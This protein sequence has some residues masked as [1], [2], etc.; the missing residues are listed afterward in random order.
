MSLFN[1][2]CEP[3][4]LAP[5]LLKTIEWGQ[6]TDEK[7]RYPLLGR[8]RYVWLSEDYTKIK[9]LL[10]DSP[11]SWSE[12]SEQI[13]KQIKS[14]ETYIN[15]NILDRDNV[16]YEAEFKPLTDYI[17]FFNEI[18]ELDNL[19]I[20]KGW[21]SITKNPF[22][23]FDEKMKSI[24]EDTLSNNRI[25]DN[26]TK[27][28][29][30]VINSDENDSNIIVVNNISNEDIINDLN[31]QLQTAINNN[32]KSKIDLITKELEKYN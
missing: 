17:D 30:K 13:E 26:M 24:N 12:E 21:P 27:L 1:L 22:D 11:N 3:H 19:M 20:E 16:Y 25:K 31:I 32:D 7:K 6:P 10:K 2:V 9:L 4:P 8:L 15:H 14:H 18:I 28:F 29:D 5:Y 23:I